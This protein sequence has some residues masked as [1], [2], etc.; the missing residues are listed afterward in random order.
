MRTAN[1]RR[2]TQGRQRFHCRHMLVDRNRRFANPIRF[3]DKPLLPIVASFGSRPEKPIAIIVDGSI[4]D[5]YAD[6]V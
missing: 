5:S 4:I 1:R 3:G 2:R 6:I